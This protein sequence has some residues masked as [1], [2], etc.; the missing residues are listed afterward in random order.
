MREGEVWEG[1][2]I[3]KAGTF[4]IGRQYLGLIEGGTQWYVRCTNRTYDSRWIA[5]PTS[6][7]LTWLDRLNR[8]RP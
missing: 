6:N 5:I 8:G 2:H 3:A 1:V 7:V 4:P